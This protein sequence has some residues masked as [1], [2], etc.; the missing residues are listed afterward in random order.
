MSEEKLLST[1]QVAERYGVSRKTVRRWVLSKRLKEIELS[2]HTRR[3]RES[4]LPG[5]LPDEDPQETEAA[6]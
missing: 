2:A 5:A 6:E 1:A 4:D 3:F